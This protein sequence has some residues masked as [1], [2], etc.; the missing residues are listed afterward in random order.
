MEGISLIFGFMALIFSITIPPAGIVLGA[1]GMSQA[2]KSGVSS[3]LSKT[4][5]ILGIVFTVLIVVA[6]AVFI[7]FFAGL[8]SSLADICQQ[9]G[10]GTHHINGT[11]YTCS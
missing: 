5:F 4:G 9:L 1:I 3:T 8:F 2:K 11:T 7:V 6:V 10:E